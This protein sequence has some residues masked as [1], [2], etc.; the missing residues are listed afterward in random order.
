VA[1]STKAIQ[2]SGSTCR[3]SLPAKG[4]FGGKPNPS[5]PQV[6]RSQDRADHEREIAKTMEPTSMGREG[7]CVLMNEITAKGVGLPPI[8]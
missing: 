3:A 5:R 7:P 8:P 4:S 6:P 1:A 2:V